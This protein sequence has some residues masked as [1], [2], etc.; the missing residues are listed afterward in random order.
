[1][2]EQGY[3]PP[4]YAPPPDNNMVWAILSTLMCCLPLGIVSIIKANQVQGLWFSG[5]HAAAQ[6]AADEA[7]K[8]AIWSAIVAGVITVLSVI[9]V[10]VFFVILGLSFSDLPNQ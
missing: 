2:S 6:Q 3:P 9:A 1:M 8:W 4:M 10:V 5:Q 7:K